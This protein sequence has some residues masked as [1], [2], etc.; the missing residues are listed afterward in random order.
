MFIFSVT[1]WLPSAPLAF[2]GLFALIYFE[3]THYRGNRKKDGKPFSFFGRPS[4]LNRSSLEGS[5]D[6]APP[7]RAQSF[8]F[9]GGFRR[10]TAGQRLMLDLLFSTPAWVRG[11]PKARVLLY[12]Y[13]CLA[14]SWCGGFLVALALLD[15][16]Y[17]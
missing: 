14:V 15:K 3:H 10:S 2:V 12:A 17:W 8:D 6:L 1:L 11:E 7:R 13:R 5:K 4:E 9:W 16:Y